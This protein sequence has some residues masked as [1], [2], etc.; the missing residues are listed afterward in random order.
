[1]SKN[2]ARKETYLKIHNKLFSEFLSSVIGEEFVK[3]SIKCELRMFKSKYK[4][5][6][7][8][9]LS[10]V[11]RERGIKIYAE[12]QIGPSD[13]YNHFE[14][15]IKLLIENIQEGII[16]WVASEFNPNHINKVKR[17]LKSNRDKQIDFFAIQ[18]NPM[19]LD[20]LE[21][22]N[23]GY[24]LEV[25]NKLDMINQIGSPPLLLVDKYIPL[26]TSYLAVPYK[27]RDEIYD[28]SRFEDRNKYLLAKLREIIPY[29]LNFHTEKE[30]LLN[31]ILR[32]AAGRDGI[33]Y[34]ATVY[35]NSGKAFVKICFSKSYNNWYKVF[36][37]HSNV[38]REKISRD[39]QFSD[40]NR[41]ISYYMQSNLDNI[42]EVVDN[43]I[44][45]YEKFILFF[46]PF[47]YSR[48][49]PNE[50][51]IINFDQYNKNLFKNKD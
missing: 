18:I 37:S 43:L 13:I 50:I 40:G 29:Y 27:G 21:Y 35:D 23:Q 48:R 44:E 11:T 26:S 39:I 10:A 42:P 9:D 24:E 25:Y 31:K 45:V 36:K 3:S 49:D 12:Y 38:I 47:T 19:V 6:K 30:S 41:A 7:P 17:L 14:K 1:M 8:I 32:I 51:A 46:S 4:N 2:G 28:F 33:Y 16:I 5:G 15:K 34:D 20:V 22:C